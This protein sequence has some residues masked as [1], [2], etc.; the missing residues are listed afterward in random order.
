M[1]P[2]PSTACV[3]GDTNPFLHLESLQPSG[4]DLFVETY[5]MED[6]GDDI[7][8]TVVCDVFDEDDLFL[9]DS[10][11]PATKPSP[12]SGYD[13]VVAE[14]PLTTEEEPIALPAPVAKQDDD[15]L[16][17]VSSMPT[18]TV[19]RAL[20]LETLSVRSLR[21]LCKHYSYRGSSKWTKKK[22]LVA[23]MKQKPEFQ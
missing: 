3:D 16:A 7:C 11:T 21:S 4:M 13:M 1:E 17:L 22:D 10:K 23:F 19:A 9:P 8:D 20:Y 18:G 5:D 12:M 6:S 2:V 14:V 15:V